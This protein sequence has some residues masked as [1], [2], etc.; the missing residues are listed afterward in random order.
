MGSKIQFQLLAPNHQE[1]HL[2]GSFSPNQPI[3]MK[4][5]E[6]G[7]FYTEIDLEDGIYYYQFRIQSKSPQCLDEWVNIIDPYA[8]A[9]DGSS[10]QGIVRIEQGKRV[11][12]NYQWKYDDRPLPS[13]EELII[14]EMH[15]ADFPNCGLEDPHKI[16]RVIGKLDYLKDLG[17]NAIELMPIYDCPGRYSWGYLIRNFFALKPSYGTSEDLKQLIDE[18]HGRG[19]RV[20]LDGIYNHSDEGCPLLAIDRTYW[21]Y[22]GMHYPDDPDNYWGPEFNYEFYDEK[23]QVRP[24]WDYIRDVVKFWIEEYHIDGIRYDAVKQ[25]NNLEFFS[26][27][28]EQANQAA[29]NKPF[30]H[31]AEHIPDTSEIVMPNGPFHSCWHES[32]RMFVT[33]HMTREMFDLEKLQEALKPQLQGYPQNISVVNYLASHDRNHTLAE[34]GDNAIFDELAFKRAK[35]GAALLM[36]GIGVPMLSMGEELGQPTPQTPNKCSPL[37]WDLLENENNQSLFNYYRDLIKLRQ[38]HPALL[39]SN[40]EFF[41]CNAEQ[42][43]MGYVRW[44]EDQMAIAVILNFSD[45]SYTDYKIEQFP[46]IPSKWRSW[47]SQTGVELDSDPW[48]FNLPSSEAVILIGQGV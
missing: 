36:T 19:M 40:L 48:C 3:A 9:V 7:Y 33:Q 23:R 13:N 22:E 11:V 25:L 14:Y 38:Q 27:L 28:L 45:Q 46:E 20:I 24:A 18:C 4:K 34:L 26:W 5:R 15:L 44:F 29:G 6:D 30:Y 39:S 37:Q 16:Q 43:V 32:F 8:T 31:I 35:L 42:Q 17:I 1:C 12:D 41:H 2:I 10:Q 47:T 21:Y